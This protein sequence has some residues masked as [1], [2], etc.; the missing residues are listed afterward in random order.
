MKTPFD[1]SFENLKFT[2]EEVKVFMDCLTIVKESQEEDFDA[3][4]EIIS[5][6]RELTQDEI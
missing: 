1:Q 5:K 3:V 6:V 2:E 4:T